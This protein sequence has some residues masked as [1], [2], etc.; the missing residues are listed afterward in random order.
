MKARIERSVQIHADRHAA[1]R[2]IYATLESLARLPLHRST[3]SMRVSELQLS[4]LSCRLGECVQNS[5]TAKSQE[6]AEVAAFRS[7][8]LLPTP[9]TPLTI[10]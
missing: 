4:L 7:L 3:T 1:I 8:Q 5:V 10:G 6:I 2:S 9:A